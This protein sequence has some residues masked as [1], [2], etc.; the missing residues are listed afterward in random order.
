MDKAEKLTMTFNEKKIAQAS[1]KRLLLIDDDPVVS[2]IL[3]M[4]ISRSCPMV[5]ASAISDPVAAPG[6][7]I[8]VIDINFG[9][10]QEGVRL[11]EAI[12]TASPASAVFMLSSFLEVPVLK[13][14]MG[15]QC[16]GAFDKREPEDISALM[17]AISEI[18]SLEAP[19]DFVQK[20]GR[21]LLGDMA[22]LIREW[23]RRISAEQSRRADT[24]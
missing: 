22:A 4:R 15:V 3:L 13:R 12:C 11:A 18:A 8:Y 21:G 14:V 1:R 23:N 2:E 16:R 20:R 19:A 24:A 7:D 6:Y 5:E 9:G 10:K 17:R